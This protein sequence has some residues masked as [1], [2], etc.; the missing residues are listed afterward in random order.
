MPTQLFDL[1]PYP[2]DYRPELP[3]S[4]IPALQDTV[5]IGA[6]PGM[7]PVRVSRAHIG[8]GACRCQQHSRVGQQTETPRFT[9]QPPVVIVEKPKKHGA[10]AVALPLMGLAFFTMWATG[11]KR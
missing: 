2:T 6:I 3:E 11:K 9:I 1:Q 7:A 8:S 10:L 4:E 5:T